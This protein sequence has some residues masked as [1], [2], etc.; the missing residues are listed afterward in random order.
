MLKKIQTWIDNITTAVASILLLI[1]FVVLIV[2]VVLRLIPSVGGAKWASELSQFLNVWAMLIGSAGIAVRC[3]NLRVEAVDSLMNRI[4]AGEKISKVLIDLFLIAFYVILAISGK[5]LAEK[6]VVR[7]IATMPKFSMSLVYAIFPIA[8][9]LCVLSAVVHLLITLTDKGP[10]ENNQNAQG[11][12]AQLE[13][14]KEAE[15]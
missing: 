1:M 11:G 14:E 4:P 15:A 2:N 9:V 7:A 6:S 12:I 3:T 10:G 13:D 5:T 8:G